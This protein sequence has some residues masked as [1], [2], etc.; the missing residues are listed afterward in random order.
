MVPQYLVVRGRR[1]RIV[2]VQLN[3]HVYVVD[4]AAGGAADVVVRINGG[5]EAFLGPPNFNFEND[6]AVGHQFKVPVNSAQTNPGQ[7]FPH[8]V[9]NLICCGMGGYLGEFFKDDLALG[10]QSHVWE[11]IHDIFCWLRKGSD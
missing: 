4:L 8:H 7:A 3:R 10:G 1:R 2:D 9:I 6:S 11:M 5:I